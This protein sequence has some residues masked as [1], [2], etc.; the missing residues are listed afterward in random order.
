M[1]EWRINKRAFKESFEP[2]MV[3]IRRDRRLDILEAFILLDSLAEYG[4]DYYNSI[5]INK[6]GFIKG[7]DNYMNYLENGT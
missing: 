7:K 5:Y 2:K 4:S 3:G 1:L 6:V